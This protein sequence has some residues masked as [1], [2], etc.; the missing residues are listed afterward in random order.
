MLYNHNNKIFWITIAVILKTILAIAFCWKFAPVNAP[1]LFVAG[2]WGQ[3]S[4]D[5][6][7]YYLPAE[8]FLA[9]G[10]LGDLF[11]FR[12]FGYA[13]PYLCFRCFFEQAHA[14]NAM[15]VFQVCVSAISVYLLGLTAWML[16][17]DEVAFRVAFFGYF[18]LPYVSHYDIV[19]L[20]ESL[21]TSFLIFSLFLLCRSGSHFDLMWSGF[22]LTW[23]VFLRPVLLPVVI[24][25]LGYL[26]LKRINT[27]NWRGA[28]V[29]AVAFLIP[30]TCFET[31]WSGGNWIY[32]HQFMLLTPTWHTAFSDPN[33]HTLQLIN[34]QEAY[35]GDWLQDSEWFYS[36]DDSNPPP[37]A[38]T[39]LFGAE[40]I[41]LIK[42]DMRLTQTDLLTTNSQTNEQV[43]EKLNTEIND[44]LVRYTAAIRGEHPFTFYVSA[45]AESLKKMLFWSPSSRMF[46]PYES[47]SRKMIPLR[48][49]IDAL[50]HFLLFLTL[51]C[52]SF[53]VF[54]QG[55][56][57]GEGGRGWMRR[58]KGNLEFSG[59]RLPTSATQKLRLDEA[60]ATLKWNMHL[61]ML[62]SLLVIAYFYLVHTVVF[63]LPDFR[64][65]IP[66]L[67]F[68][69]LF[70]SFLSLKY[71][72][73]TS[74]RVDSVSAT[75]EIEQTL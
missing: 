49:L 25:S 4:N 53:L 7:G 35:G 45:R 60:L 75:P 56:Q 66:A 74:F 46:G 48:F 37:I 3:L 71:H 15:L 5:S 65:L 38:Y 59:Y 43:R 17:E 40:E 31:V 47:T 6:A 18:L 51:M 22:F 57:S 67:P 41:R 72:C 24:L 50:H 34:F 19:I 11:A 54:S 32:H 61:A 36:T 52:G 44:K 2:F 13:M 63:Q 21:A 8:R 64:Y 14:L 29:G 62:W 70:L 30:L 55:K 39:S 1:N 73:I 28:A 26:L 16:F 20:T 9:S 12:M 68:M 58:L 33:H 27:R 10:N 69:L 23:A 42:H